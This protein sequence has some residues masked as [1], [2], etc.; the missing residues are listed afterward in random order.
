MTERG[1]RSVTDREMLFIVARQRH[2]AL[3]AGS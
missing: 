2:E 3:L 1:R